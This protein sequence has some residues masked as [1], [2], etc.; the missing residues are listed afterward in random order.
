LAAEL[1]DEGCVLAIKGIGG[2]HLATKT[3][4]DGPLVTLRER[5]RKPGKPFAVMSPGLEEIEEYALISERERELLTSLARPIVA[6]RKLEPFPLSDLISPGL[7]TV[8][9]MLPY[10]GIHHVLFRHTEEP[11][12][13]MT[14]ANFPGEPM[15]SPTRRPW[16]GSG[17]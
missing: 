4:E 15:T 7:H 9:V 2:V 1:L 16:R 14:S 10:S 5:R 3:T 6:L 17:V 11:A 13:V 12:L 8:G